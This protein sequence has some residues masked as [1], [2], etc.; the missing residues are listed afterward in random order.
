[1]DQDPFQVNRRTYDQIAGQFVQRT[2]GMDEWLIKKATRLVEHIQPEQRMLDVGCGPGRD[3]SWFLKNGFQALGVDLSMGMLMEAQ[4]VAKPSLCQMEMRHLALA[5]RSFAG[6]W[7]NAA[8]LHLP[9]KEVPNALAEIHRVLIP[10]GRF[11]LSIQKGC[12][13]GLETSQTGDILR[14]F[15]RYDMHE[16]HEFL[17]QASFRVLLQ[18]EYEFFGRTWLWFETV[19]SISG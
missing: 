7:C 8:L 13:E 19:R 15:A 1:M 14:F 11:I 10:G 16:M 17:E 18:E 4:K 9:K 5:S 6:V 2:P 3:L 12:G